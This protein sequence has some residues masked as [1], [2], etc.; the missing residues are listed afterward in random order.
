MTTRPAPLI[1]TNA[2][3]AFSILAALKTVSALLFL[4]ALPSGTTETLTAL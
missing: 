4:T 2:T 1:D 3:V